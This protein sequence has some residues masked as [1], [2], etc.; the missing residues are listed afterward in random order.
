[1]TGGSAAPRKTLV[2]QSSRKAGGGRESGREG[3]KACTKSLWNT[4]KS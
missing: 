3:G 4:L 1:M 2:L